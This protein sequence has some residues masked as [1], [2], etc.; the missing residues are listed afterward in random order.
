MSVFVSTAGRFMLTHLMRKLIEN[1]SWKE[2]LQKG[3]QLNNDFEQKR[4]AFKKR[5][6]QIR[7]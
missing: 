6:Y 2:L 1:K 5:E 3:R 7:E 4:R